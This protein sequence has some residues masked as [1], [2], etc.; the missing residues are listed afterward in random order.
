MLYPTPAAYLEAPNKAVALVGMSGLGKT[1]TAR[2]LRAGGDWFHYSV[3]YRIGTRY[4]GERITDNFKR[5]A[6]KNPFLRDLLRS[7]SIY[8]ASNIT[9]ENLAPLSTYLGKPGAPDRGGIPFE[10]YLERQRQHR[11]AEIAALHDTLTF[12]DRAQDIYRYDH[13]LADTG[14]SI[15]EVVNPADPDDSVMRALSERALIVQIRGTDALADELVARFR[16]DPKPMYYPEDLLISL[17]SDYR[18]RHGVA[19]DAV[20]PD[21]FAAWGFRALIEHRVPRYDA[22]GRWGVVVEAHEIAALRSTEDFDALIA[23]AIEQR[24]PLASA[25]SSG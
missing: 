16:R 7:D 2:M 3:D 5:E 8:I 14:G 25:R 18:A 17:W 1:T 23:R 6:M 9:F 13:F 22:I 20:D 10:A 12:I 15:C 19:E 21:D 24:L 4:M 11:E